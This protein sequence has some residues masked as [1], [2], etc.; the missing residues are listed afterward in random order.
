MEHYFSE[1]QGRYLIEVEQ[2]NLSKIS[3]I[4]NENNIFNETVG[5]IQK[6]YFEVK[7]ELKIKIN[8]LYKVNNTWYKNY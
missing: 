1:D 5:V 7:G 8:D 6:E 2:N 4:L 3:N